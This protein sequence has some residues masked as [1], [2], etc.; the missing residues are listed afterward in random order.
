MSSEILDIAKLKKQLNDYAEKRNWKQFHSPK[1]LA[2][3]VSV[4][5][6]ELVEIFQWETEKNSWKLGETDKKEAIEDELADIML[7]LCR[8]ADILDIDITQAIERKYL[9]NEKKYPPEKAWGS[10]K[11]YTE[12]EEDT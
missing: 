12:Y 7:Y 1:N 5:V 9:K 6:A 11:K 2:M 10:S 4:E 3:A 8:M